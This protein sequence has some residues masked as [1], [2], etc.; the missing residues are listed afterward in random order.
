ML[1]KKDFWGSLSNVPRSLRHRP[2]GS[3][4][5]TRNSDGGVSNH[6]IIILCKFIKNSIFRGYPHNK[7]QFSEHKCAPKVRGQLRPA[8]VEVAFSLASLYRRAAAGTEG[9]RFA[10]SSEGAD[11]ATASG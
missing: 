3:R 6:G 1:S 9:D 5:S 7:S 11:R 10:N 4:C 2:Y 8:R